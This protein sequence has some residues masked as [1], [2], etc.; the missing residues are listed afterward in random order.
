V[1]DILWEQWKDA[2]TEAGFDGP[3]GI[4]GPFG[5]YQVAICQTCGA[6]ILL[7]DLMEHEDGTRIERGIY[8]HFKWHREGK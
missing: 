2:L 7:D 3:R 6:A 5:F 1:S 8:L 4:G